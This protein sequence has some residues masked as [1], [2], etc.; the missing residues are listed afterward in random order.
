MLQVNKLIRR[1]G[2]TG[3]LSTMSLG[4]NKFGNWFCIAIRTGGCLRVGG[5]IRS[6][7]DPCILVMLIVVLGE[8]TKKGKTIK[9]RFRLQNIIGML[10]ENGL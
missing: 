2:E 8:G 5:E 4:V 6:K 1:M 7:R 3:H 10:T 9:N